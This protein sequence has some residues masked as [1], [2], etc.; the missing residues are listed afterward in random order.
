MRTFWITFAVAAIV[1]GCQ[2][3]EEV[4]VTYAEK[5][6][7]VE[8]TVAKIG[9]EGMMCEIACGGKIRKELSELDGVANASIEYKDGE[10]VNFALVEFNPDRVNESDLMNCI[11]GISDGKLYS[12]SEMEVTHYA[13]GASITRT[14]GSD[15]VNMSNGFE[16]PGISDIL[17]S[18]LRGIRN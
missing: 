9:V 17:R 3:A 11:N 15:D 1:V 7:K 2:Q 18:F 6:A 12:V 10:A 8:K 5:E 16:L 14:V 4:K 13:P